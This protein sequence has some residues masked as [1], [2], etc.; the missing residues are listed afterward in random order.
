MSPSPE[1]SSNIWDSVA[2]ILNTLATLL[3]VVAPIVIAIWRNKKQSEAMSQLAVEADA[4]GAA[5]NVPVEERAALAE[6][7][8]DEKMN[9]LIKPSKK[10]FHQTMGIELP[11]ARAERKKTSSIPPPEA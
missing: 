11:K 1:Q 9:V 2:S 7:I 6:K 4:K 5:A 3:A 10:R 8:A